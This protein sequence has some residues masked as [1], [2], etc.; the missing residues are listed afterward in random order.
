MEEYRR[1]PK[2]VDVRRKVW[3]VHDRSRRN[4]KNTGGG[5]GSA[6]KQGGI[7]ETLEAHSGGYAKG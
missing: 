5:Y 2:I 6:E 3:K 7:G 1:K 4:D